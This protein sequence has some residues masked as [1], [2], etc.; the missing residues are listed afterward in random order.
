MMGE[1]IML[2]TQQY[3]W[4]HL[5]GEQAVS[6]RALVRGDV[7]YS[8]GGEPWY[9]GSVSRP[10]YGNSSGRVSV[11]R[12]CP[13]AYTTSNGSQE[14]VHVWHRNGIDTQEYFPSVFGLYL[15]DAE[16]NEA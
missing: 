10:A 7:V 15:G 13:D 1:I 14:C 12:T 6:H 11:Y 4:A 16:G 2:D 8:V 3:A 5:E 9:F